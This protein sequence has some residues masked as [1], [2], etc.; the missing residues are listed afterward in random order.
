MQLDS[1]RGLFRKVEFE[2]GLSFGFGE[3]CDGGVDTAVEGEGKGGV[4]GGPGLEMLGVLKDV[5]L[6]DGGVTKTRWEPA[7]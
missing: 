2:E 6:S 4:G 1:D 7:R 3:D 5:V